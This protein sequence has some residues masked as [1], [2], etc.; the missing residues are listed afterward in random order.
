MLAIPCLFLIVM[1]P[2]SKHSFIKPDYTFSLHIFSSKENNAGARRLSRNDASSTQRIIRAAATQDELG[3]HQDK[4]HSHLTIA[5]PLTSTLCLI[6]LSPLSLLA[7]Q[8][9]IHKG[10]EWS[11]MSPGLTFPG[12]NLHSTWKFNVEFNDEEKADD[13]GILKLYI[14][15]HYET[16][17]SPCRERESVCVNQ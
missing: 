14:Q 8:Y 4:F 15:A 10:A 2:E 7:L 6:A 11:V 12:Q 3:K 1:E 17:W 9:T 5:D 13:G 16:L